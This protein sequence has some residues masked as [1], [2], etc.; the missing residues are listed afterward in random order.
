MFGLLKKNQLLENKL[1]TLQMNFENNYK[2]A[3]KLNYEEY[4]KLLDELTAS[5]KLKGKQIDYY[6][7]RGEDLRGQ[8]HNFNHQNNVKTF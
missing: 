3:A 4:W 2:D 1:Q 5:G 8:M 7:Q 6:K